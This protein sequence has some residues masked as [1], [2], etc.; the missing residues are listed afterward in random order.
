MPELIPMQGPNHSA[1]TESLAHQSCSMLFDAAESSLE[2][3]VSNQYDQSMNYMRDQSC[4]LQMLDSSKNVGKSRILMLHDF[5]DAVHKY[6]W[7]IFPDFWDWAV[8]TAEFCEENH[9][10]IHLKPHPNQRPASADVVNSLKYKFANYKFVGWIPETTKNSEILRSKPKLIITAYG[11]V[12]SESSFMGIP[13]LLAG[14]HPGINFSV[15]YTARSKQ[16]YFNCISDPQ[17]AANAISRNSAI[18]FTAL[19]HKSTFLKQN[20]S[21]NGFLG[22]DVATA[23]HNTSL[24]ET[25]ESVRYIK[26]NI[27]QLL[28]ELNLV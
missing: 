12:A 26:E 24:L 15:G 19:H 8:K 1:Y 6:Q 14:D 21:L 13:T 9:L 25:N 5:F 2:R 27:Y 23:S 17:L 10:N 18:F 20:Q 3:R 4:N 7:L 16:D 28:N 11:S 22:V